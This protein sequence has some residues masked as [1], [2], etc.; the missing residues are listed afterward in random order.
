MLPNIIASIPMSGPTRDSAASVSGPSRATANASPIKK[1][2]TKHHL[3]KIEEEA[4]L[5]NDDD[6]PDVPI[7]DLGD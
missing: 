3:Q 6:A 1:Y 7:D 5:S 2:I 4:G